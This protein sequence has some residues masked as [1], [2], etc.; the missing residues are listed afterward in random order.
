[1]KEP[2]EKWPM[3]SFNNQKTEKYSPEPFFKLI[4]PVFVL[5]RPNDALKMLRFC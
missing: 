4:Q 5:Q 2:I 3:F 1:V